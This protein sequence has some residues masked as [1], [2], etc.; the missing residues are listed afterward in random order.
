MTSLPT[1]FI[2]HGAPTLAIENSPAHRFLLELGK[3]LPRPKAIL[4]ASAHWESVGGPAVSLGA[5][6]ETIHDF[7]GFPDELYAIQYPAPGA[8]ETAAN[9]AALLEQAGIAVKRSATRGLDHGAWVPLHLMYPNADIPV[10]QISLVRGASAAA[11][12]KIGEA[13]AELRKEGVLI[14][15]SGSLTHNLY[16]FR[17]HSID[18][19]VPSWVRD[20]DAWM[21]SRLENNQHESLLDYRM[22]AP[23]AVRNHP[24]DEHLMPLFV[25]MGAAGEG[26]KAER[27]HASYEY[28]VLAMDMYAFS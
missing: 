13:L 27:L 6:P 10:A 9:A 7:G 8:P 19:E 3:T 28:G 22:Q 16:E 2:S 4:V 17:G 25:A 14:V 21:K 24:T 20:F 5:H 23:Y 11:H 18:A 1:L 26:A 15:G 12:Q